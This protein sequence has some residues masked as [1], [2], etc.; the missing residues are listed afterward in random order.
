VRPGGVTRL[1]LADNAATRQRFTRLES[2]LAR[3]A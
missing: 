1:R 3:A 2:A